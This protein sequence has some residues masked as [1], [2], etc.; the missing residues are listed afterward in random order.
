MWLKADIKCD[1]KVSVPYRVYINKELI[2][3]RFYGAPRSYMTK[4]KIGET[5]NTL[6][7]ELEDSDHYDVDIEMVPGYP[8]A[9]VYLNSVKWQEKRF[10]D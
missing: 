6:F 8:T 3:E 1:T 5:W 4:E 10:E 7:I 9:N 2:T